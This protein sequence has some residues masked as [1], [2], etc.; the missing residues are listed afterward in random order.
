MFMRL[1]RI[2]P[3]AVV[4]AVVALHLA[5][6]MSQAR[7]CIVYTVR[8][9]IASML[10]RRRRRAPCEEGKRLLHSRWEM[11]APPRGGLQGLPHGES[12]RHPAGQALSPSSSDS[13]AVD[14]GSGSGSSDRGTNDSGG[15]SRSSVAVVVT[16][17]EQ[18]W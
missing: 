8:D 10:V 4:A 5:E 13:V 7:F 12:S 9:A 17:V 15:G 6:F 18:Q 2:M 11:E 3:W 16:V 14:S 1:G